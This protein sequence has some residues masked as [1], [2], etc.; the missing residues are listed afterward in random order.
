M[1]ASS[2]KTAKLWDAE[3]GRELLTLEGHTADVYAAPF[4]PDGRLI[5]TGS[6]DGTIKLWRA[7]TPNEVTGWQQEEA[8]ANAEMELETTND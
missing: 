1:T 5:A 6:F 8:K 2:D 7:A 3:T 4:S